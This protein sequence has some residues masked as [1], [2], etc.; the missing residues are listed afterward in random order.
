MARSKS[1]ATEI[2][3]ADPIDGV[4]LRA[5]DAA[6]YNFA[7]E[8]YLESTKPL[9]MAIGRWDEERI[10]S[11]FERGFILDHIRMLTAAGAVVGWLQVSDT[12]EEVHVD[13][14]HLVAPMRN[15]GTGTRIICLLQERAAASGRAVAL[16]VI[17]GNRAQHLY[18]R[19]G[20]RVERDGEEKIRMVWRGAAE[21]ADARA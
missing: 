6:D 16:N 18:E 15:H 8:L 13:Q 4:S 21:E 20:F 17:R 1:I 9:L 7:L 10:L 19:L 2:A 3:E 14:L 11:R 12:D 5:A